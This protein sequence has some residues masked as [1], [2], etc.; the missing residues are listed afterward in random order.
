MLAQLTVTTGSNWST[1]VPEPNPF[2]L[3]L[4]AKT[5]HSA[6]TSGGKRVHLFISVCTAIELI[7]NILIWYSALSLSFKEIW[8][9]NLNWESCFKERNQCPPSTVLALPVLLPTSCTSNWKGKNQTSWAAFG[10]SEIPP[11][12]HERHPPHIQAQHK[13][14]C[15]YYFNSEKLNTIMKKLKKKQWSSRV[16]LFKRGIRVCSLQR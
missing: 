16:P 15:Y 5:L 6:N 9:M 4:Q 12:L 2:L 11:F 10:Y 13:Y 8:K 1:E 3:F 14:F 7:L